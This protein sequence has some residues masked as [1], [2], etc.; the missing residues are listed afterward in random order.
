MPASRCKPTP[1]AIWKGR[2]PDIKVR[3]SKSTAS[4]REVTSVRRAR[5]YLRSASSPP[6]S[7][8]SSAAFFAHSAKAAASRNPRFRPWAPIGGITCAASPTSAMRRAAKLLTRIPDN[9]NVARGPTEVTSPR[10]SYER[11]SISAEKSASE[12]ARSRSTSTEVSTQTRLEAFPGSGTVVKRAGG[13]VK[14]IR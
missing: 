14:L 9:G 11:F 4:V 13:T 8:C 7:P 6:Q 2:K 5:S 10:Q 1:R 12:S 3:L